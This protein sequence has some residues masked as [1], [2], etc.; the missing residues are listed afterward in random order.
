MEELSK[1]NCFRQMLAAS[2]LSI[3]V[4]YT[5]PENLPCEEFGNRGLNCSG[6][7]TFYVSGGYDGGQFDKVLAVKASPNW[8]GSGQLG[9][10]SSQIT[11]GDDASSGI[12]EL[13]HTLGFYD[14]YTY[15]DENEA[16][17][18]CIDGLT[19]PNIIMSS[20]ISNGASQGLTPTHVCEKATNGVTAWRPT[21]GREARIMGGNCYFGFLCLGPQIP[22]YFCPFI[23]RALENRVEPTEHHLRF[24]Q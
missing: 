20:T 5:T 3:T 21:N 6:A 7:P 22:D 24:S 15:V 23:E 14:E 12:H 19:T 8:R 9:G 18:Y 2:K 13:L 11:S 4:V 1:A 10:T 16:N 17:T